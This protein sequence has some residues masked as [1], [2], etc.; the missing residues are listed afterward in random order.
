[1]PAG[2]ALYLEDDVTS[3]EMVRPVLHIIGILLAVLGIGM[4]VPALADGAIGHSDWVIFVTSSAITVGAAGG[5]F[6]ATSGPIDRFGV[7]QTFLLTTL[8]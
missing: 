5:L 3:P 1:M 8:A 6:L 4:L 2:H 7:K